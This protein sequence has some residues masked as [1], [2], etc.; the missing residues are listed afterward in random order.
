MA[1]FSTN[2]NRQFYVAINSVSTEP[3]KLGDLKLD[4][5]NDGKVFFKHMGKG[6]IT[7]SDLI[8]KA[9][10]VYAKIT[11]KAALQRKLQTA[12]ISLNPKVN[13]GKPISGQD[14]LVRIYIHNY[15]AP[16]DDNVTIKYGV[17]HAYKGMEAADFYTALA[18]SLT[19]NF[20]REVQPLLKFEV[21]K[22]AEVATGVKVTEVE[23]PWHLGTMS[24]EA[25][26]FDIMPTFVELD[27]EEVQW[28]VTDEKTNYVA[29]TDSDVVIGNGKKIADLEYFCMGERGDQH[30]MIGWPNVVP[31]KYMV[32]PTKE[33]DVLDIHYSFS[34]TG[35]NV[36]KSEKDII[37]VGEYKSS[38]DVI[39]AI[40]TKLGSLGITVTE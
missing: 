31:T 10:V 5:T 17:V 38:G 3:S 40:K 23:Q 22:S 6:G 29:K 16:G 20:S 11:R 33:Y 32:D 28:A 37:I 36:Q 8:D 27:G 14:Y 25:V 21:A 26:N 1:V 15:L 30:R 13:G 35:V 19:A 39:S 4:S 9:S 18:N 34:D 2:Q 7:R 24:Q 12:T